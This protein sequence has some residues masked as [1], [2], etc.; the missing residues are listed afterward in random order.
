M[1]AIL[2]KGLTANV[3]VDTIHASPETVW[4]TITDVESL[5]KYFSFVKSVTI[6]DERSNSTTSSMNFKNYERPGGSNHHLVVNDNKDKILMSEGLAWDE[7]RIYQG[8]E[9]Q[10]H[11]RVTSIE[12][13]TETLENVQHQ[14]KRIRIHVSFPSEMKR[15]DDAC[16][17]STLIIDSVAAPTS[18]NNDDN[19]S[20]THYPDQCSLTGTMAFIA[21]SIWYQLHFFFC[22]HCCTHRKINEMY[23]TELNEIAIEAERRQKLLNQ[24]QIILNH[25]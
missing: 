14:Q 8:H 24:Q 25:V 18:R 22:A 7:I 13:S 4:L 2:P 16:N 12:T 11:K 19:K 1:G 5:P 9:V 10:L 6:V 17:T 3:C 23:Q 20:Q 15:F 21:P